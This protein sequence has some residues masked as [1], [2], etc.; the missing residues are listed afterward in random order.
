MIP[1]LALRNLF[2]DRVSLMVT[3]TGIIFSVV[4]VAI[5]LGIY[6][7]TEK[8]I[9]GV[10]DHTNADL[11]IMPKGA[12]SVDDSPLLP[13]REKYI[14]LATPGIAK[15]TDL[16]IGF[17]EWR[18]PSGGTTATV[19]VGADLADDTLKPWNLSAG[20]LGD[21]V[22]PNAVIVDTAY[23]QTLGVK[24]VGDTAQVG[25]LQVEIVALTSDIRS[26]TTLPYVF[27]TLERGRTLLGARGDQSG[28]VVAKLSH[29]ADIGK[30]Q[31]D[32][33]ARL[34]D[35]DVLTT[36]QFR[37]RSLEHWLM[38]TGAGAALI[39]GAVLGIIVGM[40]I[41]AQTLYASTKD[42]L[43]EFATLR[44]LGARSRYIILVIL[45]QAI[46]SAIIGY[47]IGMMW[48]LLAVW[49]AHGSALT[50]V[51][52]PKLAVF[53]LLLTT[54]MCVISAISAII[55]VTRIDPAMVFNR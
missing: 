40:V 25:D 1:I 39:A 5:Q 14:A 55:K 3:L 48:S 19:V 28:Y 53:L 41:V 9:A 27:T 38:N 30:V 10:I 43:S 34:P 12:Q 15:A 45:C 6:L 36:K 22:K 23:L 8:T 33:A 42:H 21:V 16:A 47:T 26:F 51:M 11:W 32:L 17:S 4:L 20:S 52:T 13:G 18:K 24:Q 54:T 29:G 50:I 7:G 2:H 37:D 46:I 49:M 44:A 31:A 35:V